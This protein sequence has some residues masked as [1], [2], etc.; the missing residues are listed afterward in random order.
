MYALSVHNQMFSKVVHV[1]NIPI[2]LLNFTITCL[3]FIYTS[4]T[5]PPASCF[6]CLT[7]LCRCTTFTVHYS[8]VIIGA[9]A[10]Q[11]TSVSIVYSTVCS[12]ADQRKQSSASLAFVRGIHR[13]PVISQHKGPV[14]RKIC[15][16]NDVIMRK[17]NPVSM[18]VIPK[19]VLFEP[20]NN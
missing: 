5:L 15:P 6:V 7:M 10:S 8:G 17:L 19:L 11:I 2:F 12:G 3:C 4:K 20:V 14:T 18:E 16:F 13:R 1:K 9:T